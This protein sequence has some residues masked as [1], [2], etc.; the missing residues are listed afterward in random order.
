MSTSEEEVA[1][2]R[3][4]LFRLLGVVPPKYGDWSYDASVRFKLAINAG[5]KIV[6]KKSATAHELWSA[7]NLLRGFY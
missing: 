1:A 7:V 3:G 5:K 2:A 4:E 6:M